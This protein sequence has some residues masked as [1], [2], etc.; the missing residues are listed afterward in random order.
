MKI[1]LYDNNFQFIK[2]SYALLDIDESRKQGKP[3]YSIPEN[4][5]EIEPPKTKDYEKAFF[6]NGEWIIKKDYR[7]VKF[8]DP[9]INRTVIITELGEV[10]DSYIDLGSKHLINYI[11]TVDFEVLYNNVKSKIEEA[12]NNKL[13]EKVLIGKYYF[14]KSKILVYI[15][16]LNEI[17]NQI[18][19]LERSIKAIEKAI[20]KQNNLEKINELK[21]Q[22][23][24]KYNEIDS[25][26]FNV[27][28]ENKRKK[29]IEVNFKYEEFKEIV[30]KL[31][32][33]IN[34]I[35][36]EKKNNL[37]KINKLS[38]Y[39]LVLFEQRLIK[40]EVNYGAT[41]IKENTQADS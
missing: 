35:N 25:L 6:I 11:N 22:Q 32:S 19:Q 23:L 33:L 39:E 2:Q 20:E 10:P 12:A 30:E 29:E 1:Y 3:V 41:E 21:L 24:D 14:D 38:K 28:V 40:E 36:Q 5:T 7:G 4:C 18:K 17:T 16:A 13:R 37:I 8:F 15:K 26:K 9:S 27:I 34:E 31:Q